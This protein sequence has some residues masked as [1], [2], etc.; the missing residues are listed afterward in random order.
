[1]KL[2]ICF[3]RFSHRSKANQTAFF[4]VRHI[5]SFDFFFFYWLCRFDFH[6]Q[7]FRYEF[8]KMLRVNNSINFPF[9]SNFDLMHF[10]SFYFRFHSSDCINIRS[11]SNGISSISSNNQINQLVLY[12]HLIQ[13]EF[14]FRILCK[15]GLLVSFEWLKEIEMEIE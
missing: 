9:N 3:T 8:M 4:S 2:T 11:K 15:W 5:F 12:F 1:M 14:R 7:F 13:I 6:N 10:V